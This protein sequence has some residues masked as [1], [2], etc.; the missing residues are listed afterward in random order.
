MTKKKK[1]K[2]GTDSL[3][4]TPKVVLLKESDCFSKG[5][6]EWR[7]IK[8]GNPIKTKANF[9]KDSLKSKKCFY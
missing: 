3:A 5:I 7:T 2:K 4:H 1:K 6:E 9:L 8:K